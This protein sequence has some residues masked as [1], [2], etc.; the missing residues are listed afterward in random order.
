[1]SV[2][3]DSVASGS[4]DCEYAVWYGGIG[5]CGEGKQQSGVLPIAVHCTYSILYCTTL[6][7]WSLNKY[8]S[9]ARGGRVGEGG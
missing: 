3:C 5:S 9:I 8:R 6:K 2:D 1:M 7:A 4:E